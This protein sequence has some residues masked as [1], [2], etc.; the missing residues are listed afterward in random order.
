MPTLG[1]SLE[2]RVLPDT[3]KVILKLDMNG[4]VA[5]DSDASPQV[6]SAIG[7][8]DYIMRK[9]FHQIYLHYQDKDVEG[10]HSYGVHGLSPEEVSLF[11][12]GADLVTLGI[13]EYKRLPEVAKLID[14]EPVKEISYK[15]IQ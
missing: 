4:Q 9:Q 7:A 13:G 10:S 12:S 2:Q 8:P 3:V 5:L 6:I 11:F 14:R 1:T 15:R